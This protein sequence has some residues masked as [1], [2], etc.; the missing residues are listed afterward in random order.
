MGAAQ[1]KDLTRVRKS[2]VHGQ[3]RQNYSGVN[4]FVSV[5][6]TTTGIASAGGIAA[7]TG[8]TFPLTPTIVDV[9]PGANISIDLSAVTAHHTKITL[10]ENLTITVSNPPPSG[11]KINSMLEFIQDGT[12]GW[13]VSFPGSFPTPP[14]VP[15]TP[16]DRTV[17]EIQTIDG[18]STYDIF[19]S[20]ITNTVAGSGA[21]TALDNLI[22]TNINAHL[23]PQAG[24]TLGASGSEWSKAWVN[25]YEIGTAGTIAASD[26]ALI[27]DANG[28]IING[29][30]TISLKISGTTRAFVDA[31]GLEVIGTLDC[32][33]IQLDVGATPAILGRFGNDGVD[34]LVHSGGS[35]RNLSDI[36]S[37]TGANTDLSNLTTT[38]ANLS[39]NPT[40]AGNLDL[41]SDT[42]YW[43]QVKAQE[44]KFLGSKSAP[45]GSATE[46]SQDSGNNMQL[47]VLASTDFFKFYAGG[48]LGTTIGMSGSNMEVKSANLK[49]DNQL[50]INDSATDPAIDGIFTQNA[51]NVKVWSGGA[52]RNLSDIGVAAGGADVNLSNLASPTSINQNLIPQ[53]GK[54]L[55][56][57][58]GIWSSIWGNNLKFG[59]AGV[60]DSTIPQIYGT[61]SGLELNAPTTDSILMRIGG[62]TRAFVDAAGL[63]VV[64]TLDCDNIQIDTT[65]NVPAIAGFFQNDGFDVFVHS[66]G[67]VRNMSDIN[68]GGG[69]AVALDNLASVAINTSLLPA[70]DDSIDLGSASKQWRDLYIDGTANIDTASLSI[71]SGTSL[72]ITSNVTSINSGTIS[73]GDSTADN[74]HINAR[75]NSDII[76]DDNDTWDLGSSSLQWQ[77][78]YINGTANIDTLNNSTDIFV[79]A[80]LDFGSGIYPDLANTSGSASGTTVQLPQNGSSNTAAEGYIQIKV[81]GA[82]KKL[83]Y[84]S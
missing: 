50:I 82:I 53:S 67:S 28:P 73:L 33:A 64:G 52:L 42:N 55:G 27:A 70:S 2:T 46:I 38:A 12:G 41:G 26:S 45:S 66:G 76:P 49:A 3:I 36:A 51:G 71:I 25:K 79:Q 22:T 37:T 40:S 63:E 83:A 14:T 68:G 75:V 20:L 44:I 59:T 18:G 39:I 57:S 24:K 56:S 72:T 32:D 74:L 61:A 6:R 16:L 5:A 29:P 8:V 7:G 78:L 77:N 31:A 9:S 15:S 10:T 81:N 48:V 54:T 69:A 35:V 1:R 80:D 17:Y 23:L 4:N 62:T 65:A 84:W 13:T 21:N 34:V 47:G 19:E 60:L 30:T 43:D 11:T 58:G